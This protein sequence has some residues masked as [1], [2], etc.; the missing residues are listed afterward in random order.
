MHQAMSAAGMPIS[1]TVLT[2]QPYSEEERVWK[3]GGP[4]LPDKV[5]LPTHVSAEPAAISK[6]RSS[7]RRCH[8]SFAADSWPASLL[9]STND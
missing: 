3:Q 2:G 7:V 6:E 9:T 8:L 4:S 1:S 5:F